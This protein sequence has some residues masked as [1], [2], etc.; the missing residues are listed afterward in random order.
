MNWIYK[1][2]FRRFIHYWWKRL[3]TPQSTDDIE[4]RLEY[5]TRVILLVM[6]IIL[7]AFTLI[8]VIFVLFDPSDR[9][10]IPIM[11][12]LDIGATASVWF[13]QRNGWRRI[14]FIPSLF[15]FL[16]GMVGSGLYGLM[17][18]LVLFYAIAVI[19]AAFLLDEKKQWFIVFGGVVAHAIIG[20]LFHPLT[21]ND[22]VSVIIT[23]SGTLIGISF[24]VSFVMRQMDKTMLDV[25]AVNQKLLIEIKE[26]K[27]AEE[28]KF[29]FA[30]N[31]ALALQ[32]SQKFFFYLKKRAD[33]KII[34]A[35]EDNSIPHQFG[36]T[37]E[38]INGKT[39]SEIWGKQVEDKVLPD[40]SRAFNGEVISFEV[41]LNNI[42]CYFVL[43][44]VYIQGSIN[45][46]SGMCTDITAQKRAQLALQES[47][48]R[49]RRITDNML[50]M[51]IQTD[52]NFNNIFISPSV[53]GI[54]GYKPEDLLGKSIYHLVHAD[55][56]LREMTTKQL[57]A[58][59]NTPT[60][61]VAR[62]KHA[63]GHY[64]WL[65]AISKPLFSS[66]NKFTGIIQGVRDISENR[67]T[68][69][70]LLASEKRFRSVFDNASVGIALID[71]QG[72]IH[73]AN[74]SYCKFLGYSQEELIGTQ[75][76]NFIYADDIDIDD[77]QYNNLEKGLCESY[78]VDKRHIH[79]NG[80][81]SW[82]RL[83]I[84]GLRE[85]NNQL[86]FTVVICENITETKR[87]EILQNSLFRISEA[88]STSQDL[89][90]LYKAVHKIVGELIPADNFYIALH[91]L[92]S[93]IITFPY[94]VDEYDENPGPAK[95]GRGLTEYVLRLGRPI[96]VSPDI[97]NE[98]VNSGEVELIGS[99]SIDWVGVPL[100]TSQNVTIGAMVV[101]S[102]TE[103]IRFTE[104][105]K[106]MLTFVSV[107]VGMA[108]E[109]KRAEEDLKESEHRWQFALEGNGDGVWDWNLI[110]NTIQYSP[111]WK[112]MF[113]YKIEEIGNQPSEWNARIH[114]DDYLR[115]KMNLQQHFTHENDSYVLEYRI[116]CK[117]GSYK[118]VLDR[119]KV[120]S[121]EED[122]TPLR[123]IGTQSDISERKRAE[124]WLRIQHELTVALASTSD[125]S[126]AMNSILNAAMQ[127]DDI[128]CGGIYL[129]DAQTGALD[130][131]THNGLP[132]NL[133]AYIEHYKEDPKNA[134]LISSGK[135]FY[136][137]RPANLLPGIQI[138]ID[139]IKSLAIIPVKHE[140]DVI[141]VL[142]LGSHKVDV[143]PNT[144]R[145]TLEALSLQIGSVLARIQTQQELIE[146]RENIQTLFDNVDDFLIIVNPSLEIMQ[147]NPVVL[148]RLGY[149][150][151]ELSAMEILNI[152][153]DDQKDKVVALFNKILP[154]QTIPCSIPLCAKQNGQIPVES[155]ITR[156]KWKGKEA[157][158]IIS[159]DITERK[160]TEARLEYLSSH[161]LLTG[162][163]NRN[164]FETEMDRL[165][166]SRS[167][168]ITILMADVDGLKSIND[169]HGHPAGDALLKNSA[170]IFAASFR[171]D[172]IVARI[173]GDE[174][175]VLLPNTDEDSGEQI[176][177][178][179]LDNIKNYNNDHKNMPIAL[180]IGMATGF[181]KESLNK[182][183]MEADHSMYQVKEEKKAS[184]SY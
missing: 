127:F 10:P 73:A 140:G 126:I 167:F 41:E 143:I 132:D 28:E 154:E 76:N 148:R 182:I 68:E 133:I 102:Y 1:D 70:A 90:E 50:D 183:F 124:E 42:C 112:E 83:S 66:D 24:L 92:G 91:D 118:W 5:M 25:Q 21:L 64:V 125:L 100:K 165:Q 146:S 13:T 169:N 54:L 62:Y 181:N 139:N 129:V 108:I 78:S 119:G 142:N 130:I 117:D 147:Y 63:L 135:P 170:Q 141:A 32:N 151:L 81:L 44:P 48:E 56:K 12:T 107:Q 79:K 152:Y 101:Q 158:Y 97:F 166:N 40:I 105:D 22:L 19:L 36:Y 4:A 47:E 161:D 121:W 55:D 106:E 137:S 67:R 52:V 94:Y 3:T 49:L 61:S 65:E 69:E 89:P 184:L 59:L 131:I 27:R 160:E 82:G 153:P 8:V 123:M 7:Y 51:V 33:G 74:E 122:G 164:F 134:Q 149:S 176:L 29:R 168:P 60:K 17:H 18:N 34:A 45:E 35:L 162:L 31:Y 136:I 53:K 111:R 93:D 120:L 163:Y 95:M 14:K 75:M 173:G 179:V 113:G 110:E 115:A 20:Q 138:N 178:R 26:R 9:E 30:Q 177:K 85:L 172:D 38:S 71:H 57:L 77:E 150:P 116:R 46:I 104:E 103:G 87:S 128:D 15:F 99:P 159:R 88:A 86:T 155:R 72:F 84:S 6:T 43:T 180:S 98:L 37:V 114:P 174:F 96:L 11:L 109:R 23:I 145:H 175:C 144:T 16:I 80:K 39:I 2:H 171:P 58:E 156:G 157:F